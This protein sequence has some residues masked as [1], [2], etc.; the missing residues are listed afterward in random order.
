MSVSDEPF[1]EIGTSKGCE[2]AATSKTATIQH[3]ICEGNRSSK[4]FQQNQSLIYIKQAI[5]SKNVY[6]LVLKCRELAHK[7]SISKVD[8]KA[9]KCSV[10]IHP[11]ISLSENAIQITVDQCVL[12]RQSQRSFICGKKKY[13]VDRS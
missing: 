6:I 1:L 3:W 9:C 5:K 7:T 10:F 8:G 4:Y 13:R 11:K 2:F 12:F